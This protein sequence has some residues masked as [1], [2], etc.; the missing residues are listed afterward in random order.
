[1][2]EPFKNLLNRD[3]IAA[4][5]GHLAAH[6]PGFDRAAFE[7]AAGAGLEALELKA[8]AAQITRALEAY[9]PQDFPAACDAMLAALHPEIGVSALPSDGRGLRGWAVMP[10]AEYVAARGLGDFDR[11]MR[12]L[13]K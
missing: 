9:L 11:S 8:R 4:I 6:A 1:M 10:L 12:V 2:P 7:A 3:V 13:G 5:G